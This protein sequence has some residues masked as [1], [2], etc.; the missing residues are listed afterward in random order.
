MNWLKGKCCTDTDNS[1]VIVCGVEV[2]EGIRMINGDVK[3]IIKINYYKKKKV[4]GNANLEVCGWHTA[5]A[6]ATVVAHRSGRWETVPPDG[7][8]G[9]EALSAGR[10]VFRKKRKKDASTGRKREACSAFFREARCV[11]MAQ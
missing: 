2:G 1:V 6:E 9:L 5:A 8:Q 3:N 11:M 10:P 7:G 4:K